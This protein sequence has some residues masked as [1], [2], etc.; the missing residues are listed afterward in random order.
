[1]L[2]PA[3][4]S[5]LEAMS[6]STRSSSD[7]LDRNGLSRRPSDTFAPLDSA[8]QAAVWE[9]YVELVTRV[10]VA[11]L[12]PGSGML[13]EALGSLYSLFGTARGLLR[14]CGAQLPR[15]HGESIYPFVVL[16]TTM[17]NQ[18]LRPVLSE[19]HPL[20][21][22]HESRRPAGVS[23]VEHERSWARNEELRQVLAETRA[24]LGDHARRLAVMAGVDRLVTDPSC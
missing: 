16:T 8:G 2:E 6:T 1:M 15:P 4:L 3:P 22:D 19:W 7:G 9:L 18:D 5:A 12:G 14:R 11:D 23:P 21:L 17:L 20:L 13:R 24:T 10:A